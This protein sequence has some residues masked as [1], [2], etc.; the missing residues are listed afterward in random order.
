TAAARLS[1]GDARYAMLL[2]ML[3]TGA[4]LYLIRPD[5]IG[6]LAAALLLFT[7]RCFYVL[8]SAW[9]EPLSVMLLVAVVYFVPRSSLTAPV[10]FGLLIASNQ[11]LPAAIALLPIMMPW[12]DSKLVRFLLIA[13]ITALLVTLPLALWNFSAFW[14]SV[15]MLQLRQPFRTDSL[16]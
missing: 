8:E 1:I 9:T 16:G 5:R 14:D 7:P 6:M 3:A 10:L 15:V 13:L 4:M 12:F 2:A 11:Y